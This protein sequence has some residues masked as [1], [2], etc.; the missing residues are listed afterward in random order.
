MNLAFCV[1]FL[2]S[3]CV[4]RSVLR[5]AFCRTQGT[6]TLRSVHLYEAHPGTSQVS[7]FGNYQKSSI[8]YILL[9]RQRTCRAPATTILTQV[10]YAAL[11]VDLCEYGGPLA[12]GPCRCAESRP[13]RQAQM[14]PEE[15]R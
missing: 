12:M 10:H 2:R 13:K 7:P 8:G 1:A 4:L 15:P 14:S 5:S 9:M 3:D 6:Q 11:Q